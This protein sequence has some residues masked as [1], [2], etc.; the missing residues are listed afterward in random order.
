MIEMLML[1]KWFI[2]E[3][4]FDIL[5]SQKGLVHTRQQSE[6]NAMDHIM[7]CIAAYQFRTNKPK[8]ANIAYP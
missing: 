7:S 1:Q 6:A 5:K 8:I 4:V 3:T 2:V